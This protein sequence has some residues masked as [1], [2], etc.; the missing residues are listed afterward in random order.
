MP[1]IE[2]RMA[3]YG[4][5][6]RWQQFHID[7]LWHARNLYRGVLPNCRLV[8]LEENILLQRRQ[9]DVPGSRIPEVYRSFVRKQE[10]ALMRGILEHNALDLI[11]LHKLL[12]ILHRD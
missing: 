3:Y 6:F 5:M 4:V 1:Y 12:P 10:P 8:T 9:D 2:S 11:S 7:L